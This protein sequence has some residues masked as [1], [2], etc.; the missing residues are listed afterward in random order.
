[1]LGHPIE[2]ISGIEEARLIYSGVLR[3]RPRQGRA[4]VRRRHRR[5]QHRVDHRRGGQAARPRELY[6]GSITMMQRHFD[7]GKI[8]AKRFRRAEVTRC[9]NWSACRG[10]FGGS[11][12]GWRSALP[13]RCARSRA[14]SGKVAGQG[15]SIARE[16][17]GKLR[18]AVIDAGSL[19]R[20][21]FKGLNR[22]RATV[23]PGGLAI[24]SAIF[25]MLDVDLM[26]VSKSALREGLLNDC[27]SSAAPGRAQ[28][29]S[30]PVDGS[31]SRRSAA[32]AAVERT[33]LQLLSR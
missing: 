12:G 32:S 21:A 15:E 5:R 27:R 6:M 33:V 16:P 9:R 23:F 31:L 29:D 20:L 10:A 13:A 7:D 17:L 26:Q 2:I 30:Q 11:A 19:E 22:A 3:D 28:H 8:N 25:E 18:E 4:P 14:C 24:L 1:V